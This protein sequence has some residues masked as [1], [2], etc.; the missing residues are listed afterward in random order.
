MDPIEARVVALEIAFI[1]LAKFLG[2]QQLISVIQVPSVLRDATRTA[3]A[4][5]KAAIERLARMI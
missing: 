1:E 2:R 3:D 4:E 5:T